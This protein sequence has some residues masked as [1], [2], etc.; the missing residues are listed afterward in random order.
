MHYLHNAAIL[1]A[2]FR[3]TIDVEYS[4][5]EDIIALSAVFG[6]NL[7]LYFF[8]GFVVSEFKNA[9]HRLEVFSWFGGCII[10]FQHFSLVL[11]L[12]HLSLKTAL[13]PSDPS[14]RWT[15]SLACLLASLT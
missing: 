1:L 11:A 3:P 7:N 9:L 14:D 15:N 13:T 8:H 5:A 12:Y 4:D 6:N 10:S 2:K